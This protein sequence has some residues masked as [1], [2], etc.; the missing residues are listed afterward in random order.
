MK[1][2]GK[3]L[4]A[5]ILTVV[6]SGNAFAGSSPTIKSA[7]DSVQVGK[8]GAWK[9]AKAGMAIADTD[10]VKI[11][12]GAA[13]TIT[14]PDNTSRDFKG[15]AVIP[16]R[17]LGDKVSAGMSVWF[18][19]SVQKVAGTAA[20]V[21]K[22]N[23][24][25]KAGV[26]TASEKTVVWDGMS[27]V[28]HKTMPAERAE[29]YFSRGLY[30]EAAKQ[31]AEVVADPDASL[32]QKRRAHLVLGECSASSASYSTALKDLDIAA[33]PT[34]EAEGTDAPLL[35]VQS[36]L[37]RGQV[38]TQLGNDTAAQEDFKIV[39]A[40]PDKVPASQAKFLLGILAFGS[41][42]QKT[43]RNWFDQ[44]K[45]SDESRPLYEAGMA[46]LEPAK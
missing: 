46:M 39:A 8:E 4:G 5:V 23:G 42:D 36:L 24:I 45:D 14:L 32:V 2:I 31:A 30:N 19:Q 21:T 10:F 12:D 35:R 41:K 9:P 28:T 6:G 16:G 43:A 17:R 13:A 1:R 15:K 7:S 37:Q 18:S 29:Y 20:T 22:A 44:L 33:E 3:I 26:E 25:R 34:T 11:P 40:S 27:G 38:Q